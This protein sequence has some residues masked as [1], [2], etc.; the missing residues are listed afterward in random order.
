MTLDI[1]KKDTSDTWADYLSEAPYQIFDADLCLGRQLGFVQ[2]PLQGHGAEHDRS[3]ERVL[4][5]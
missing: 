5:R 4:E 3:V 1:A 2:E